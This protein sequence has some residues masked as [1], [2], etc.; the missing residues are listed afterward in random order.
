MKAMKIEDALDI[1]RE[2]QGTT[3]LRVVDF[4]SVAI[5]RLVSEVSTNEPAIVAHG[6]NRTYNRH[7]R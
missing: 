6:Y 3:E 1:E 5:Q 2:D 7:N 4:D